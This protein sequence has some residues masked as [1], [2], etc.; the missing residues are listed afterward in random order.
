M[1]ST[2]GIRTVT[3]AAGTPVSVVASGNRLR[4]I[5]N[6]GTGLATLGTTSGVVAGN[7]IPLSAAAVAGDQGG[8]FTFDDLPSLQ[9]DLYA[10]S[11]TGT[12]L[13]VM[14]G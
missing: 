1:A 9:G 7:G 12:T 10:V 4:A 5:I 2:I 11:A 13:A 3:L 14:E 8:G 6:I